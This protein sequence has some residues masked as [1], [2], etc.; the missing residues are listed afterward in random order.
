M[1]RFK[2]AAIQV[3][4]EAKKPLHYSDITRIA[5]EKGIL[6]TTGNTPEASMNAQISVEIKN[7]G[8]ASDFIRVSPGTFDLNKNKKP[9]PLKESKKAEAVEKEEEK[10]KVSSSYIGKGGEHLVCAELLFRGFN[11]SIMSVD[12]GSP[13][14]GQTSCV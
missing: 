7:L 2:S 14:L 12:V 11:A 13:R 6:E 10:E 9:L 4:T 3:L 8:E 1:N 5:I